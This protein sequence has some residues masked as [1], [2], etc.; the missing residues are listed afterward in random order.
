MQN[1][2]RCPE[3]SQTGGAAHS[4]SFN[5]AGRRISSQ[6]A[7]ARVGD[8]RLSTVIPALADWMF[9]VTHTVVRSTLIALTAAI[10]LAGCSADGSTTAAAPGGADPS[11]VAAPATQAAEEATTEDVTGDQATS[12]EGMVDDNL[13]EDPAAGD[14]PVGADDP[15]DCLPR[16]EVESLTGLAVVQVNAS[17]AGEALMKCH[18]LDN[19]GY[20]ITYGEDVNNKA[21]GISHNR[22]VAEANGFTTEQ[23]DGFG[24][25]A[26]MVTDESFCE[27]N[28]TLNNQGANVGTYQVG[29]TVEQLCAQIAPLAERVYA[30]ERIGQ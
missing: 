14:P 16:E 26:F 17:R 1:C 4:F 25:G 2:H 3:T 27:Y 8:R 24:E 18:Y 10:A 22:D 9:H 11:S 6:A 30:M 21:S 19:A 28:F 29:S 20:G 12:G 23:L 5:R 15:T 7:N 13:G